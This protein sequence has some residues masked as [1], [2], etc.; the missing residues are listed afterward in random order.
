MLWGNHALLSSLHRSRNGK[1]EMSEQNE[2]Q[3]T[4]QQAE[5]AI[6]QYKKVYTIVPSADPEITGRRAVQTALEK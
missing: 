2:I 5:E 4:R 3:M 1:S 6:E